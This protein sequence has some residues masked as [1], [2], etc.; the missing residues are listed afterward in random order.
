MSD[1]R[2]PTLLGRVT[3]KGQIEALTGLQIGGSDRGIEIGGVDKVVVRN[4]LDNKPYIPGSSLK[5]KIRSL[6]ERAKQMGLNHFS[7]GDENDPRM[8]QIKMH[9]CQNQAAYDKCSVCNLFGV[10]SNWNDKSGAPYP[11]R[12]VVRDAPLSN[13]E[14]LLKKTELPYTE[15]KTEVSI[16]RLTSAANPRTFERVPAGAIFQIELVVNLFTERD[17]KLLNTLLFGL[18]LLEGDYLGGQGSRGYG[19]VAFKNLTAKTEWFT[20]QEL[21]LPNWVKDLM[22]EQGKDLASLNWKEY[23]QNDGFNGGTA[24]SND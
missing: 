3:I 1:D 12:I 9:S 13:H 21:E 4:S 2:K 23:A 20:G 14:E 16:D 5:G 11:T 15:I 18:G 6:I 17:S 10:P 22:K 19:K 7:K 24:A 8:K